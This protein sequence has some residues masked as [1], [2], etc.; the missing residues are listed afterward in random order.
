M[1][2]TGTRKVEGGEFPTRVESSSAPQLVPSGY[3]G[4]AKI[5][6]ITT[7]EFGYIDPADGKTY[8][9]LRVK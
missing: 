9:D 2:L 1:I 8:V 4:V 3:S 7:E 6:G 5:V